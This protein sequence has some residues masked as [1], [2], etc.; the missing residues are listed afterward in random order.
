M[1]KRC[2][3]LHETQ[4]ACLAF[5]VHETLPAP[6]P[7]Y[8]K[9]GENLWMLNCPHDL[10]TFQVLPEVQI[11]SED[12]VFGFE[13]FGEIGL[14][15]E[16]LD[17]FTALSKLQFEGELVDSCSQIVEKSTSNSTWNTKFSIKKIGGNLK[18][19]VSQTIKSAK[20]GIY[21]LGVFLRD[22]IARPFLD[23]QVVFKID[24]GITGKFEVLKP[25]DCKCMDDDFLDIDWRQEIQDFLNTNKIN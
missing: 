20:S 9:I 19:E 10:S 5:T 2:Q 16:K 24:S 23:L 21:V 8:S 15:N 11:F 4:Q 14:G 1:R 25:A 13:I 17:K 22:I 7:V 12:A 18:I 3:E 6:I